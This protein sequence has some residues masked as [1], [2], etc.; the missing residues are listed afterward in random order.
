MAFHSAA[1]DAMLGSGRPRRKEL[2]IRNVC[3]RSAVVDVAVAAGL[4]VATVILRGQAITEWRYLNADET[5]LLVEARAALHSPVPFST[6]LTGTLGPYWPLFLAGLATLGAPLTPAFAHLLTAVLLALTA[7]ALFV[8]ASRAIGRGPALVATLVG[9]Y[10]S[11]RL[12]G[13]ALRRL[14]TR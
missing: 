7:A 8:A 14:T 11:R 6:W 1:I 5:G 4:V 10:L 12:S 13:W 2:T 9:G 3:A